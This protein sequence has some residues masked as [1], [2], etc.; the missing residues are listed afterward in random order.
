MVKMF[1]FNIGGNLEDILLLIFY[2][3][4]DIVTQMIY[5]CTKE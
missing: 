4:V 3:D 1:S 2:F 5:G